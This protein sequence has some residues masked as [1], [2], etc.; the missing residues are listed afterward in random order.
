[1]SSPVWQPRVLREYAFIADGERG[2]VIGPDGAIV[3]LCAPRWDSPAVFASLIGG[4]GG[5]AVT[6]SDPWHV[7]GGYY[8]PGSLIWHSRWVGDS[9][10]ECREALAR[11]GDPH[12]VVLLRRV[13]AIEG[14]A[15]V[16]VALEMRGAFGRTGV[17]DL[18]R[19]RGAWTGRC[20]RCGSGCPGPGEPGPIPPGRASG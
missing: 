16:R 13:M 9:V 14:S 3:W 1:M 4:Q 2:A 5:Y 11:P 15:R 19:S 10:T 12:R 6:P 8:E 20:G 7:W 17:R 18:T